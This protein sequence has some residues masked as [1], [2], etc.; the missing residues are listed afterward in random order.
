AKKGVTLAL[1]DDGA[2]ATAELDAGQMQQVF[3]NLV[4]NA[5]QAMS[6]E[7]TVE[8]AIGRERAAAPPDQG[9]EEV[10]CIRVRVRDEGVGIEPQN[11]PHIFEPFFTTKEVGQG[12]G[13][14]L[15]VAY[16]IVREHKGW[17][18]AESTPGQG[19]EISVYL[20]A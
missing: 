18:T 20:P 5:S 17:M 12:T 16:G 8:I 7:G 19:S 14:G 10:P 15:S 3:T 13:L 11:L 1:H 6:R 4:M 2:D 9:G